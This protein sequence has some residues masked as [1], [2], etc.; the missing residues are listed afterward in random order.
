MNFVVPTVPLYG[1]AQ[2]STAPNNTH[3]ITMNTHNTHTLET[4]VAST[5]IPE[6]LVCAVVAQLGGPEN[7]MEA[8]PQIAEHGIDGGWTGFTYHND[9]E[10]FTKTHFP[11][12]AKMASEQ[13]EELGMGLFEMIRGF[14]CFGGDPITDEEIGLALY[15]G[16]NTDE[17]TNMLNALAWYAGEEVC[18]AYVGFCESAE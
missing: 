11:A 16:E 17:G 15:R 6:S 2:G 7:F 8:A 13:A 1:G 3:N 14:R 10:R 4:F 9:T 5:S 12:I 18:R